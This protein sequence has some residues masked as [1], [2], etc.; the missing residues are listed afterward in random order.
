MNR[1]LTILTLFVA[2]YTYAQQDPYYT[3][4]KDVIDAYNPAAAGKHH[5]D[6]C[7]SGLTHHQWRDYADATKL[8]GSEGDPTYILKNVAPVTYNLNVSTLWKLSKDSTQF[9]GTGL[10]I[11]DDKIAYTKG[12][13]VKLNL[14][15][16]KTFQGGF[17]EIA[18]GFGVGTR[19]WG[20]VQPD[21]KY[22]DPN[23]PRIPATGNTASELDLNVGVMYK[24]QRLSVLK[25]F[26]AGLSVTNVNS[27]LYTVQMNGTFFRQFVPHYY[28]VFGGNYDLN[29]SIV[30]EPAILAKFIPIDFAGESYRPQIDLNVTALYAGSL[31]GGVA[32]RQWGTFDAV[33]LLIGYVKNPLEIG[34]SYDITTSNV[35][36]V[37]NGTHEIMVKY[38]IPLKTY[39][40][41][42]PIIRLTPRFL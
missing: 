21:Y 41:K 12:T 36:R 17:S 5:G 26:Y 27:P 34:Y 6:I 23:D 35:Q 40:P 19:N 24:Q 31:R 18:A 37:S 11:I 42:P 10:S 13:S 4:F 39:E 38:C 15:Y 28:A 33:S 2:A 29:G 1:A 3:H 22:L 32:F 9:L 25:D 16:K 7:L 8:R 14:N 30:L 20:W